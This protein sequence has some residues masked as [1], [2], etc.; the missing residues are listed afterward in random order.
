MTAV[1]TT[2][3]ALSELYNMDDDDVNT[4][5][6]CDDDNDDDD[7]DEGPNA[8]VVQS[9]ETNREKGVCNTH[10]GWGAKNGSDF[11]ETTG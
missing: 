11:S 9:T 5:V 6:E 3:V 2:E 1:L 8:N 10:D 4:D 7:G